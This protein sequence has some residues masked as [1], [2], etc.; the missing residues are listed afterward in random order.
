MRHG[1]ASMA[2]GLMCSPDLLLQLPH[3]QSKLVR[4]F[5]LET[6]WLRV[7]FKQEALFSFFLDT[8]SSSRPVHYAHRGQLCSPHHRTRRIASRW[9]NPRPLGD[10]GLVREGL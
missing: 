9:L 2:H 4:V 3:P 10:A 8:W 1:S 5:V 6:E 7:P